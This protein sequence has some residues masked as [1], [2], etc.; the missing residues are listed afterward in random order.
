MKRT[1]LK[2][3]SAWRPKR[4]ALKKESKQ[5]ISVVQRKLW[6]LCRQ[7]VRQRY[8]HVCYTCGRTN[9]I[10]SNCQTGHLW[11]KASLGAYLKYDLRVLRIQCFHCNINLGGN[12][13]VFYSK[14]LREHGK[15]YIEQ[16]ERDKQVSVRAME[17]YLTL[18]EKYKVLIND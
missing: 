13:A 6:D 15:D 1:P 4:K 3:K 8:P 16:L 9:L 2:R 17:H 10:G 12:G 5:K 14:V 7:I 18:I 11:P